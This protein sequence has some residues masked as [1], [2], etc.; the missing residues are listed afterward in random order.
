MKGQRHKQQ[1]LDDKS[2]V[3]EDLILERLGQR[4]GEERLL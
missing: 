3:L 1:R 4:R 2:K